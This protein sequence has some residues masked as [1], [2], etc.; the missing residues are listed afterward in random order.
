[1]TQRLVLIRH[2][3]TDWTQT[4][5]HTGL[6]DIPLNEKGK[7]EAALLQE[8]LSGFNFACVLC[9]PL[10]RAK[11]TCILAGFGKKAETVHDLVEWDYGLYDGLTT[12]EILKQNPNWNL[13]KDGAIGGETLLQISSR[14]DRV[15]KRCEQEK[16]DIALFSSGHI[17]RV[18]TARYLALPAS[19]GRLFYLAPASISILGYEHNARVIQMWNR[20]N[21]IV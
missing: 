9:S 17:L 16:G 7:R 6:S 5:R 10:K 4:D 19:E 12:A 14:A 2:G 20:I 18:L 11:E 3:E 1:M 13:F 21:H 8:A 15:L